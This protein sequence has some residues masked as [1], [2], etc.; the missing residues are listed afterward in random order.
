[1]NKTYIV[2]RF[3]KGSASG[4]IAALNRWSLW[5]DVDAVEAEDGEVV[6]RWGTLVLCG[7]GDGDELLVTTVA[8]VVFVVSVSIV[9][10]V[11]LVAESALNII[12]WINSTLLKIS[13]VL[14]FFFCL[15]FFFFIL[16][17]CLCLLF[18]YFIY[19]VVYPIGQRFSPSFC[20]DRVRL[21]WTDLLKNK[22]K[23]KQKNW[24]FKSQGNITFY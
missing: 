24:I 10:S 3:T 12:L 4:I 8:T 6:V 23:T 22:Y 7:V 9:R 18:F 15:C 16:Y 17:C 5:A 13:S 1:M 20:E 11:R 14:C 21:K 2:G 19:F